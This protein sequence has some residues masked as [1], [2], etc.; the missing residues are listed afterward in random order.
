MFYLKGAD[1]YEQRHFECFATAMNTLSVKR[2]AEQLHTTPQAV[3][4]TIIEFEKELGE[5]LFERAHG[6]L[7]PEK[8]CIL[9]AEA[10]RENSF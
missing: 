1:L 9:C 5:K 6:R 8:K 10:C 3:S 2:T 4:K 7:I